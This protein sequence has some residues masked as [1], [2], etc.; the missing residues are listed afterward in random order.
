MPDKEKS[1]GRTTADNYYQIKALKILKITRLAVTLRIN[2][3]FFFSLKPVTIHPQCYQL[4][5]A[6]P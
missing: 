3:S 1:K 5:C 6:L 2:V 4:K